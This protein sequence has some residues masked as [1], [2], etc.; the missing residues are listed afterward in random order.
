M[1]CSSSTTRIDRGPETGGNTGVSGGTGGSG[2]ATTGGASAGG[3][4][5]SS[6]GGMDTPRLLERGASCQA[7][8][9][10]VS[11]LC[12]DEI[13]CESACEGD[14][15][16]CGDPAS[17]GVCV[18][19]QADPAC[20]E[21]ACPP[22]TECRV[23]PGT[24][25][26]G[27]CGASGCATADDCASENVAAGTPCEEERG[28]CDGEGHCEIDGLFSDGSPCDTDDECAS[29]QCEPTATGEKVCC[30]SDCSGVCQ[31]CSPA[32]VCAEH[33]A[34]DDRCEAVECPT[35]GTCGTYPPSPEPGTC[36]GFGL[37]VTA[38]ACSPTRVAEVGTLC[39]DEMACDGVGTCEPLRALGEPCEH[40]ESCASTY[41]A[42]DVNG[43]GRCSDLPCD[44]PCERVTAT[45]TCSAIPAEEPECAAVDCPSDDVC[46]DYS[47]SFPQ[48]IC[49]E[50]GRCVAAS[51]CTQ[52]WT[53][54]A[55]GGAACDC[56][57]SGCRLRQGEP[58]NHPEDC[59]TTVCTA[60]SGGHD[61]CC[62]V[63]CGLDEVCGADGDGCEPAPVCE[64]TETRCSNS[65]FQECV[66]GQWRTQV[67]CGIVGCDDNGCKPVQTL[68]IVN[69]EDAKVCEMRPDTNFDGE[70][71]NVDQLDADF[72]D[73][74]G[75]FGVTRS[76]V[77][78]APGAFAVPG[79][80]TIISAELVLQ[81]I[82]D[83][84]GGDRIQIRPV[85]VDWRESTITWTWAEQNIPATTPTRVMDVLSAAGGEL[86]IPITGIVSDWVESGVAYGVRLD[87]VGDNG[88]EFESVDSATRPRFVIEYVL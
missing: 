7:S 14:C 31:A 63:A 85:T 56:D 78:P 6:T 42:G 22:S 10:C 30:A 73:D 12:V 77:R 43:I 16:T 13:C 55:R 71:L 52:N 25:A 4:A 76:F 37:C 11:S 70:R 80:A 88:T 33:P 49:A 61:I 32:G 44:G 74:D 34:T 39:G 58:C 19:A 75:L 83:L 57:G 82:A 35:T 38:A 67:E 47:N 24:V 86:R 29:A 20:P 15:M 65:S 66:D 2:S 59:A 62:T 69:V 54:A 79:N 23:Y 48:G 9:Q 17:P 72:A 81:Q 5:G 28:A 87:C 41:C 64:S 21:V 68:T 51:D 1:A 40:A 3:E 50:L 84:T 18:P 46:R 27:A 53:A 60:G 45:G 36:A 8:T 26:A